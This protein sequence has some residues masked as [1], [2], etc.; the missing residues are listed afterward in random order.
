MLSNQERAP[1]FS[2]RFLK[3]FFPISMTT[4]AAMLQSDCAENA[5]HHAFVTMSTRTP[6]NAN[7]GAT[8]V[9]QHRLVGCT[10]HKF[11]ELNILLPPPSKMV[12]TNAMQLKCENIRVIFGILCSLKH[13]S[14]ASVHFWYYYSKWFLRKQKVHRLACAHSPWMSGRPP[15]LWSIWLLR[16]VYIPVSNRDI[17]MRFCI[18]LERWSCIAIPSVGLCGINSF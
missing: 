9:D 7:F 16:G 14:T 8:C 3:L 5:D 12:C 13:N 10:S 15:S 4:I 1:Y 11:S 17:Y 18:I 2:R 6:H